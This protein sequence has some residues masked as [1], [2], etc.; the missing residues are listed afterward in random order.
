MSTAEITIADRHTTSR[1][2][3]D[4]IAVNFG[5]TLEWFDWAIYTIFAPYFA[6]QFFPSTDKS[7]ALLAALAVFA[8]GFLTR[9]LGGFLF[10]LYAD[11]VGRKKSLTLAMFITAGGSLVIA[12]APTFASVGLFASIIL[13]A[14]RLAQGIA[15]GGEMGTSITYLV[16]RAP[17][18]RRALYG[19]T[20][21]MSVVLGTMIA[22]MTGLALNAN[23][24]RAAL[25]SWGWRIPFALGGLLGLYGLYL[26][27]K[28]TETASFE[29]KQADGAVAATGLAPLVRNW[30]GVAV[31]FGL[32]AGGS[33]MFYTWLIYSPTFAQISRGLDAKSALTASLIA[34]AVFLVAIP[35][36]GWL[37]DRFGRRIFIILFG[38]GFIAATFQLDGLIDN[39]FTGLLT[40]MVIALLILSC[41]FGV[42]TAVWAEVF[43]TEIRATGVSGPLSLA[44]AIFGG[45][46]PYVNTYLAQQGQHKL[47]LVYLM[48]VSGMTL[49]TGLLVPETRRLELDRP[50]T[51]RLSN[52]PGS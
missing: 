9:P 14:A 49:L 19:S 38:I 37:A 28:L 1:R 15:H 2:A 46:A 24:D 43:P 42:N 31:V 41:L 39:S 27:R 17:K 26:R 52:G 7:A 18:H 36:V 44:T 29:K 47:F 25:E 30:R 48:V 35:I 50:N 32:S 22:T 11:R 33:I 8:A 12:C 16:E 23:L 6:L 5:N 40:A 45:T 4:L 10:G 3:K 13:L 34:Q 20:S 21:W 51:G